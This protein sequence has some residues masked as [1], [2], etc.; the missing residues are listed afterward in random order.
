MILTHI[1]HICKSHLLTHK[2]KFAKECN[3]LSP[4]KKFLNINIL[5]LNSII[6]MKGHYYFILVILILTISCKNRNERISNTVT[7]NKNSQNKVIITK[8]IA[9]NRKIAKAVFYFENSESMFG[10]VNG[11]T[12]YVDVISEL[13]EKPR[14]AEEK[15]LRDF[16]F[17]NGGEKLHI[18]HIGNNPSYLKTKLNKSGFR[19]GDITK[20][21]LNSMFQLALS[22]AKNDTISVLISDAIY[23]IGQ[24]QA[25]MNALSTEGRETRS[26]FIERL[27]EG[28]LQ[29]I[30]IKLTSQFTGSYF[31]VTGGI[32][33]ID[34]KRPFY[35]WIFGDTEL[36]NEYFSDSYIKSLKGYTDN[37]RFLKLKDIQAPYQVTT[38]NKLGDFKFDKRDKNKLFKTKTDRNNQGFQ[39][40]FAVDYS[41]LPFSDSYLTSNTN[42]SCSNANF[43]IRN[44]VG[45]ED[46]KLYGLDFTPTHL[47]T[48][49]TNRSPLCQLNISLL[50]TVPEWILNTNIDDEANII[51]DT[52]HTFGFRF[53]T[54]AISEA[55]HHINQETKI[56]SFN[57]ELLK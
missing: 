17:V 7:N 46:I 5:Q 10:Y 54:N 30:I 23:D 19:C 34:Q 43:T 48:V 53:L 42:Y 44:V 27:N 41:N 24:P 8:G 15:T 2:P 52:T 22:K 25:P 55:Y 39:F 20:S 56:V 13:S 40:T 26:R 38:H 9:E 32:I 37:V 1:A 12:E 49:F 21:N 29:T 57:F 33:P 28:D 3:F 50:N 14:F 47:V 16:Y 51:N 45:I 36:L 31:P 4:K 6:N 35:I 18:S 11:F